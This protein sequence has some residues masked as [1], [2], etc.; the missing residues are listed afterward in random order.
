MRES[1]HKLLFYCVFLLAPFLVNL[2]SYSLIVHRLY[3]RPPTKMVVNPRTILVKAAMINITWTLPWLPYLVIS[4]GGGNGGRDV[5]Q[6]LLYLS[7]L[8]D[9]LLYAFSSVVVKW[10]MAWFGQPKRTSCSR[11]SLKGGGSIRMQRQLVSESS[12]GTIIA[13]GVCSPTVSV[14]QTDPEVFSSISLH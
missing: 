7:C 2:L 3:R 14:T 9:P 10:V 6:G 11:P 4:E 1:P 5:V 8:I 12:I 13:A